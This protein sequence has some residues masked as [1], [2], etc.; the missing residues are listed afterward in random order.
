MTTP[1]AL[2]LTPTARDFE[3][4]LRAWVAEGSGLHP[5]FVIPGE[6]DRPAPNGLYASVILITPRIVG[7][8]YFRRERNEDGVR[9]DQDTIALVRD[10]YAIQ[11]H[12]E[13]STDR[14][15]Q[16]TVWASSPKGLEFAARPFPKYLDWDIAAA[17][18]HDASDPTRVLGSDGMIYQSVQDSAGQDPPADDGTYW[19]ALLRLT[20]FTFHRISDIRPLD[21]V[22]RGGKWEERV[23][24]EVDVGYTQHL[25]QALNSIKII[26]INIYHDDHDGDV[27]QTI[28]YPPMWDA[29]TAYVHPTCVLGS[30]GAAYNSVQDSTGEDPTTDTSDTY[31]TLEPTGAME[32]NP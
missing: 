29:A 23:G 10:R 21:E 3:R 13:E 11:W 1:T 17:Y 25:T 18:T 28:S 15:R 30:D 14:G 22:D 7:L 27:S 24:V 5:T 2:Q 8:P 31:W 9:I 12:R 20:P 26:N 6:V 4:N 16:F 19:A 32:A